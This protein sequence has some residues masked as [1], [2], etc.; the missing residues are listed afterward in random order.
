LSIPSDG[1]D[2]RAAVAREWALSCLGL[3]RAGFEPASADA[4]FRRYFRLSSEDG[5]RS[6]VVMDAPPEREDCTPFVR[7]AAVLG[8]AG[9]H[10]PRVL[11]Q[12]RERGFLLLDDLGRCTYLQVIDEGNADALFED[13]LQAVVRMQRAASVDALPPYDRALL[14]RE[15]ALFP[16]WFV[17]RHLGVAFDARQQAAWDGICELLIG[18]ALAQPRVFVHRDFMPRNLMRSDPNPGVLDFQDAVHGPVT[19]DVVC[20]FKDAFLSWPQARIDKWV[21]RYRG[22]A[23]DAGVAQ[24]ADFMRAF[25]LMGLQRHLKVL[26]IFARIRHRDGKPHYLED[27]PRFVR[28]VRDVAQR[29][30]DLAPLLRLF[31]GLGL[32]A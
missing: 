27:A 24:P 11:H 30:A 3:A 13:A 15:L 14:A 9:L 32:K 2:A 8:E 16:D 4:S 21:A 7:I 28:Y 25:D 19:Y 22:L 17:A 31:D 1:A 18:S 6:W 12:D 5:V 26:G 20:L 10:V 29:Y 23:A